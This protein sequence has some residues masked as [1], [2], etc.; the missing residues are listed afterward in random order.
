MFQIMNT[1]M[2]KRS[3]P[4]CCRLCLFCLIIALL[5][6]CSTMKPVAITA[7]MP[8]YKAKADSLSQVIPDTLQTK[9]VQTSVSTVTQLS[10]ASELMI[11]ACDNYLA[12][13]PESPKAPE[14]LMIKAS[15]L[16]N[17]R[18]FE[19]SR[20]VYK[21][22]I[23]QY[24][25]TPDAFEAMRMTAQAFYEEKQYDAAQEWYRKLSEA[26]TEG[27]DKQEA[28]AR[29]AESI[30]RMAEMLEEQSRFK[31]AALQYERVAIEFPE[32]RIAD[33]A[34]F[35]SGLAYEKQAEWTHAILVFQR[36]LQKYPESKL[37]P[38]AQFRTAKSHE[39]LLQWDLAAEA[40]LRVTANYPRSELAPVGMYNAAFCFENGEK[41]LE[42]AATFE[43]M[44]QLYPQ[45][46]DAADVLF[47]AG[48]IYGK[49]KDWESVTR[50]NQVFSERFGNDED[51]VIQ[52]LCMAG[53]ALYMQNREEAA[54][55]QLEKTVLTFSRLKSPSAMN[56]FYAAKALFTIGEINQALMNAVAL[57]NPKNYKRLLHAKSELLEKTIAAYTRVIKFSIS[58]WI[59]RSIFQIG[60]AYEDFAVGIFKQD[61]NSSAPLEERL[62]L[63]LGIAQAIE[64]YFIDK[65]VHYH[66]QNVK[67]GIKEKIEDKYV[68]QS[69]QKLTY[70]PY[71]AGEHFVSLVEIART[72]QEAGKVEGFALIARKL[73][74][75]QKIAPFQEK[76]ID[77]FL[78]C[79]ELGTMY[80]E[81]DEFFKKASTRITGTS[82]IV[83]ETYADV[84][85]IAREAPIPPNFD[86]YEKFIYKTK[87]L[88]QVESYE[89]QAVTNYMKTLKI[90]EAYKIDDQSVRD[91]RERIAKMLFNRAWCFDLLCKTAFSSPP[92]PN[93]INEAEKE[94][95]KVRFEEI[96]LKFQEQAF[97]I[98]KTIL[99]FASQNY[100]SGEYVKHAY[101]RLYQ[102]FPE[103]YG[104]REDQIIQT[105][106]SSGS[107]WRVFADSTAGWS[108]FDFVDTSWSKA[109]KN[110]LV[111]TSGI[112]GFP[113]DPP[114]PM[115]LGT[116]HQDNAAEYK[117]YKRV[118]FRRTFTTSDMPHSAILHVAAK[119]SVEI[120]L[121]GHL[122]AV[123][124][125]SGLAKSAHSWDLMGKIRNGKNVLAVKVESKN[126][127]D[128]GFYPLVVMNIGT[129]IPLPKPPGSKKPL[130]PEEVK[131]DTYKFPYIKNFSSGEEKSVP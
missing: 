38:K 62:A 113:S 11:R 30:F 90:A 31:D 86:D 13:N 41:L 89:D 98:Y 39:K 105:E 55:A 83:G 49:L 52:A 12:I 34:L 43:K 123:D 73:Q 4:L 122:L 116:G 118:Y 28:L 29:I 3:V 85:A 88:K 96:G 125:T 53:I 110:P 16:Y 101:V 14:V 59:T 76:A 93:G 81:T 45:S 112:S 37:L 91:S 106:I 130:L 94:E 64:T 72:A 75:L 56:A 36:L 87:L 24:P 126:D 71:V 69:R 107:Q 46:D 127:T 82:F 66:E 32:S 40:Y 121:N 124:T 60:Q 26:A 51:R 80:Q 57:N 77:L 48:E 74:L 65:A 10:P 19:Q 8:D 61:R 131:I 5:D 35:N 102:N 6:S 99:S 58:E 92:F 103:E 9:Q 104:S 1:A 67:L 20:A 17:T 42:A 79:L 115:W 97:D 54:L 100:A 47:R 15:L 70:L 78:K 117:P 63:E 23:D 2:I 33:I 95:Y 111:D 7:P 108:S 50:V 128:Y 68:L 109:Q 129:Q 22:I 27:G 120:F 25:Q 119:G 18:Q 84:V 114:L 44:A 21:T